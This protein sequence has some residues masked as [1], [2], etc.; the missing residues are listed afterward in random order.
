[1]YGSPE[2]STTGGREQQAKTTGEFRKI[3]ESSDSEDENAQ[4]NMIMHRKESAMG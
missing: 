4:A 2:A 3:E 1:M